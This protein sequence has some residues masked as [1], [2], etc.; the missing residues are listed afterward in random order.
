MHK[1]EDRPFGEVATLMGVS[2]P[3]GA[4]VYRSRAGSMSACAAEGYSATEA[5]ERVKSV[6]TPTNLNEQKRLQRLDEASEW[7]LRSAGPE[8]H[9]RRA[10]RVVALD[11]RRSGN[12]AEFERLQRGLER[13]GCAQGAMSRRSPAQQKNALLEQEN[14]R[15]A[16]RYSTR[17]LIT[18][19]RAWA[20][21]AGV[22]AFAVAFGVAQYT[23]VRPSAPGTAAG[24]CI[25]ESRGN[26]ARRIKDD[27][28]RAEPREHG[29]QRPET[30]ARSVQR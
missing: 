20:V 16:Q 10:E 25:H 28:G 21:A 26:A 12:F 22:V 17:R 5:K 19:R 29:F 11:R 30:P 1:I 4:Q 14:G 18:R 15:F 6:T 24:R 8:A 7:L 13:P 2:E 9:G 3:H 27:P 23:K